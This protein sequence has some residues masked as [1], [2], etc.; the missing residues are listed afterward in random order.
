MGHLGIEVRGVGQHPTVCGTDAPTEKHP[1]PDV[2]GTQAERPA[3]SLHVEFCV[4]LFFLVGEGSMLGLSCPVGFS[5]V[6]ESRLLIAMASL[7]AEYGL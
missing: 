3:R 7:V 5:Q 6:A 2:S 4:L 1:A